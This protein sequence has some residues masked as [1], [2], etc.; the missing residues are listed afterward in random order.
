[1]ETP[2]GRTVAEVYNEPGMQWAVRGSGPHLHPGGE[3]ATAELA[4][5]AAAAGFGFGGAVVDL[6]SALGAPARFIARRFTCRVICIDMDPRMHAAAVER[7]RAEELARVIQ[8][9]LARTEHLPLAG[10]SVDGAWSQDAL[11]HMEKEPVLAEVAR[12]LKPG[13]MFA[14]TDFIARRGMTRRDELNLL[15]NWA[16][17]SLFSIPRYVAELDAL[18]FEILL[19]EDRTDAVRQARRGILPDEW[20]WWADF[21]RRWGKAE[22]EARGEIGRTW[23]RLVR[24]GRGGYGMFLARKPSSRR[25]R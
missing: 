21:E 25:R 11:C 16:F 3:W 20:Q 4:A 19:A 13:A 12:V 17:P 14:F 18:G 8:P 6:A 7:H 22:A 10:A 15:R 2:A 5:K 9:V 1:M 23:Q 24:Q